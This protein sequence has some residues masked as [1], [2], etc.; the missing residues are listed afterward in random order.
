[1]AGVFLGGG[2][3]ATYSGVFPCENDIGPNLKEQV[4]L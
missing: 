2:A 1:M 3:V 4:K